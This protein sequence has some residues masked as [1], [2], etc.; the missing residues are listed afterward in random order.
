[1]RSTDECLAIA[2]DMEHQAER[3]GSPTMNAEYLDLA[4]GWR[5]VAR[6][7]VWQDAHEFGGHYSKAD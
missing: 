4:K 6:Q 2:A 5:H 3:C 1:M 7:A